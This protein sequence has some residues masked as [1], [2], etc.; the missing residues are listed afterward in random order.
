MKKNSSGIPLLFVLSAALLAA[1]VCRAQASSDT[2]QSSTDLSKRV[3]D[4]EKQLSDLQSQLA[5][6]KPSAPAPAAAPAPASAPAATAAVASSAPA[7]TTPSK[8]SIAS[9]LGPT[10][11]SGFVDGYYNYNS[12]QPADRISGLRAFDP[13][14]NSLSL[15]MVELI[16]DKAP[17]AA[18]HAPWISHRRWLRAGNEHRQFRRTRWPGIR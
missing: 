6:M 2:T 15:N 7:D 3:A 10:S 8:V 1:P 11:I 17:D 16:V 9:L 12:N 18:V 13:T 14:S 5:A 4:L